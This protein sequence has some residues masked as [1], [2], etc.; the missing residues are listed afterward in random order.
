M[1]CIK[2]SVWRCVALLRLPLEPLGFHLRH[3]Y[4]VA[5]FG[6]PATGGSSAHAIFKDTAQVKEL[7]SLVKGEFGGI[8]R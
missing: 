4:S 5:G 8:Q 1:R 7:G 3:E 2:R 6:V